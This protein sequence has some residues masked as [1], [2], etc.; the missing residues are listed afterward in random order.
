MKCKICCPSSPVARHEESRP[1]G[2]LFPFDVETNYSSEV[3][4]SRVP[5]VR[6]TRVDQA[7]SISREYRA[8]LP[9]RSVCCVSDGAG[10]RSADGRYLVLRGTNLPLEVQ[11]PRRALRVVEVQFLSVWVARGANKS[12]DRPAIGGLYRRGEGRIAPNRR[13]LC[14]GCRGKGRKKMIGAEMNCRLTDNAA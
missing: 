3:R 13:R 9:T 6:C 4:R 5:I 7:A 8:I 12:V 11:S 10:K 1:M 14:V 2:A